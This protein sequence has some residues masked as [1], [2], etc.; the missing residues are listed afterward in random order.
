MTD[1]DLPVLH[2]V[3]DEAY[4]AV[5]GTADALQQL[6]DVIRQGRKTDVDLRPATPLKQYTTLAEFE[7]NA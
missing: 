4:A 7:E 2:I 6:A 1:L 5:S 3:L